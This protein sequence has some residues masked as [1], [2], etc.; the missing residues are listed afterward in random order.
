MYV[1]KL[2]SNSLFSSKLREA[3]NTLFYVSLVITNG[4]VY[5]KNKK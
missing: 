3:L 1:S 5:F 2:F 4:K